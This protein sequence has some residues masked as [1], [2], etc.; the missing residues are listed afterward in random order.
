LETFKAQLSLFTCDGKS[1]TPLQSAQGLTLVDSTR[2]K[3]MVHA[4]VAVPLFGNINA[5][6]LY[7]F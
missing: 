7:N 4:N 5:D 2:D 1:V 3:V 6:V